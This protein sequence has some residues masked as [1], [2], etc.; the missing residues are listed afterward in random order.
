M[1]NTADNLEDLDIT[2]ELL[3][4]EGVYSA[5]EHHQIWEEEYQNADYY[6]LAADMPTVEK[7]KKL[8]L[9]LG[10]CAY[11]ELDNGEVIK[12]EN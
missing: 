7:I 6:I 2:E 9:P 10:M 1:Y 11:I 12:I 5:S 8:L 3:S 4:F